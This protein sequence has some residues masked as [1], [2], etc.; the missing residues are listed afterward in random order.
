MKSNPSEKKPPLRPSYSNSYVYRLNLVHGIICFSFVVLG[1]RLFFIQIIEGK[2]YASM[3]INNKQQII[4]L[5]AYR[6]EI[7]MN[8]GE[9]AVKNKEAFSFFI[10]PNSFPNYKKER[11]KWEKVVNAISRDFSI[12]RKQI[13]NV[14]KRGKA[15]PYKSYLL[16]QDMPL[17]KVI[18]L[19]ENLDYYPGL[20]YQ[21]MPIRE[22]IEGELYSHITGYIRRIN[23]REYRKKKTLGYHRDSFLGVVGVEAHYDIDMR[24]KDGQKIQIVDARGKV[25]T[26][27]VPP[28]DESIPGNDIFL[29]IDPRIQ[30]I[31]YDMM[32]GYPGGCIVTRPSTG[33]VL[34]L[35][36]YP[37]YNPNIFIGKIEQAAY[38]NYLKDPEKPLF[39]RVLTGLYPPSSIFKIVTA[40]AALKDD[41][42]S[43]Y[44]DRFFCKGGLQVGAEFKKCEGW[45]R[46]QNM[47]SA[48][49]LSCNSYFYRLGIQV[50]SEKIIDFGLRYFRL[51]EKT[52]IDLPY[53][54]AGRVPSHRW[55]SERFGMYW[56]DG[57]TANLSIGQGFLLCTIIQ[58]N[59]IIC[60]LANDGIAFRPY[61]LKNIRESKTGAIIYRHQKKQLIDLPLEKKNIER[62]QKSLREVAVWGTAKNACSLSMDIA[63]KTG[64]AQN[65]QGRA[66]AWF[67]CYAPYGAK[68]P[69]DIIAVTVLIENG[70]SGGSAAAPF[71][72]AIMESIFKKTDVKFNYK[73]LMQP[74]VSKAD[75]YKEWLRRRKENR[76]DSSYLNGGRS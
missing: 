39:N 12:D 7:Y 49:I 11:N 5:P 63:G 54:K 17:E 31:V 75:I 37:S 61:L 1:L 13:I 36:S 30:R 53:E 35:Y 19:A 14:L 62:I 15:N 24:G 68:N 56:W 26:E 76:L 47:Y 40:A 43:F 34:A 28:G 64:T 41:E 70:G 67:T 21:Q 23:D 8:N 71:A 57:D 60:A 38:E 42:V 9:R 25:K 46:S 20:F 51:G 10:V 2:K 66:H 58:I 59:T 45:H 4:R 18:N 27:T 74:W 44:R 73:R 6:G 69:K 72:A 32:Q 65:V 52:A 48:L 50:G 3:A 16:E 22:Y 55:K 29:T 33:E